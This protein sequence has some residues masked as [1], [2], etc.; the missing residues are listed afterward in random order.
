MKK[1]LFVGIVSL[2]ISSLSHADVQLPAVVGNNMVLQRDMVLPIW[3]WADPGEKVVITSDSGG[4]WK[5]K[6]DRDGEWTV[7]IGP[8]ETGDELSLTFEGDNTITLTN[9]LIGDVWVCSGQSNMEW[10]VAEAINPEEEIRNADYPNIRL[11]TMERNTSGQP[12]DNGVGD[13]EACSF[14]T[15]DRFSAV[16][17]FFGRHLNTEL[18]VPIGLIDTSWG[19]TRIEP[20][21]PVAG[22][23]SVDELEGI[24]SE[25]REAGAEFRDNVANSLDRIQQWVKDSRSAIKKDKDISTLPPL[26]QH[27]LDHHQR[28]TGLFN[29]MVN[30]MVPFGIRGAIWYQGE[31]NREDGLDYFLKMQA[32]I[33]G[34]R[35]EWNQGEFPFYIVQLAPYRYDGD[36]QDL[37]P[38]VWEAQSNVLSLENTGMAVTVDIGNLDDIHPRNKQDVGKRLALW[39]LAK[40]YGKEDIVYSGPTYKSMSVEGNTIRIRF[41]HMGSGLKSRDGEPLNWFSVAGS[42]QVFVDAVAEIDDGTVLVSSDSVINPI[43]V[44]FGWSNVAEPNLSNKEGLPASPFRTDSW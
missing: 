27:P 12:L 24:R 25:I 4:K 34:W 17:Y 31:S 16:A 33:N 13:W 20:W 8:F 38:L 28:P 37:L 2:L 1:L 15:I 5:T 6:A 41:D 7:K 44:R 23:T 21:T 11:F 10:P 29:A 42:D 19:G 43:A 39:A 22:F 3:G 35:S 9:I 30:P 26:P 36:D 18:D 40:E 32:L 14:H